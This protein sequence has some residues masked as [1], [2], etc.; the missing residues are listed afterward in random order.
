MGQNFAVPAMRY[1][2]E[3]RINRSMV[4]QPFRP[5]IVPLYHPVLRSSVTAMLKVVLDR[6]GSVVD[7]VKR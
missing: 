1:S 4:I 3:W 6:P 5:K 7:E 2:K